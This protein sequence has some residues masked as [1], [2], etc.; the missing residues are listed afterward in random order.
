[1]TDPSDA[2]QLRSIVLFQ[3]TLLD[4][5]ESLLEMNGWDETRVNTTLKTFM[6]SVLALMRVQRSLGAQAVMAQ[7]EFVRVHRE[8]LERWLEEHGDNGN[9]AG[10][11]GAAGGRPDD[12]RGWGPPA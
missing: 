10:S 1:V 6:A 7:K 9:G 3:L 11:P 4:L 12:Q 2:E 8:R 5:Y